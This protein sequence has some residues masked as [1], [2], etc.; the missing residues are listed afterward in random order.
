MDV[1]ERGLAST[2]VHSRFRN[3]LRLANDLATTRRNRRAVTLFSAFGFRSS[4]GLRGFG[5]RIS[6]WK[7][8]FAAAL[9]EGITHE[10][11]R[12]IHDPFEMFFVPKTLR[13]DLVN[14]FR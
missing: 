9:A 13:I 1:N 10:A 14:I 5:P 4:F 6:A 7:L 11:L 3:C 12:F 2:G 8:T